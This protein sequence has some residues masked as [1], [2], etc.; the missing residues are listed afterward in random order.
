MNR[1]ISFSAGPR[2][3]VWMMSSG[4]TTLYRLNSP[5]MEGM[6][7]SEWGLWPVSLFSIPL[8]VRFVAVHSA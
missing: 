5:K 3:I 6:T 8:T 2:L 1:L 7:T 4:R